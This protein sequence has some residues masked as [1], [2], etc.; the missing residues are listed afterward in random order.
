MADDDSQL[1]KFTWERDDVEWGF[2]P[3]PGAPPIMTPEQREE[4]RRRL[5]EARD[6]AARDASPTVR[7]GR[8]RGSYRR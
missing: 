2:D 1:R 5:G 3:N 7:I 8:A 6:A 4:A